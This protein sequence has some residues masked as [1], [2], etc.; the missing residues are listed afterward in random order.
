[1]KLKIGQV[2]VEYILLTLLVAVTTV[3]VVK[4]IVNEVFLDSMD[5]LKKQTTKCVSSNSKTSECK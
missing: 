3:A 2:L 1:M 5:D 4:F